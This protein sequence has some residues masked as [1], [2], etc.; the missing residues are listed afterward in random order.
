[1][2]RKEE[3]S[4]FRDFTLY[5]K[6]YIQY[7]YCYEKKQNRS[8]TVSGDTVSFDCA[9]FCLPRSDYERKFYELD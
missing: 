3:L 1:M 5:S 7:F 2:S 8:C 4:S 9:V 6:H